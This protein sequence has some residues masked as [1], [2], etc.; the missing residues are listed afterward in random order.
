MIQLVSV[1]LCSAS[2]AFWDDMAILPWVSWMAIP[3]SGKYPNNSKEFWEVCRDFHVEV[4]L[5][6]GPNKK[7]SQ[8]DFPPSS[9]KKG[10]NHHLTHLSGRQEPADDE[11]GVCR[12]VGNPTASHGLWGDRSTHG[13][14]SCY[15]SYK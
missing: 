4:S 5:M 1:E 3:I 11:A 2:A 7:K 13:V 10:E 6:I 8:M 14:I 9:D 15:I 12:G